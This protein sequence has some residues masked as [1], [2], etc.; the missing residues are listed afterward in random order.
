VTVFRWIAL[1]SGALLTLLKLYGHFV[2]GLPLEFDYLTTVILLLLV[3][4][5]WPTSLQ[6]A[7]V[8]AAELRDPRLSGYLLEAYFSDESQVKAA[9]SRALDVS[10]GR[11][12]PEHADHFAP[13]QLG[14]LH[15]YLKSAKTVG[16]ARVALKALRNVA[17]AETAPVLR[18]FSERTTTAKD[19]HWQALATE[20]LMV[21][22]EI[23]IKAA[24]KL[25]LGE[26]AS[27]T[28]SNEP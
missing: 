6:R 25:M 16:T 27:Q 17:G 19:P 10:L 28:A 14:L 8:A 9:A 3:A 13:H 1:G 24:R 7:F 15:H 23:Q 4:G 2:K 26:T 20:A 11:V 21:S 22:G 12:K 5:S 18:E